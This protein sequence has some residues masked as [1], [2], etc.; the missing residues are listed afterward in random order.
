VLSF[1][2]EPLG[3]LCGRDAGLNVCCDDLHLAQGRP[4]Q[5]QGTRG[6]RPTVSQGTETQKP[7]CLGVSVANLLLCELV[8]ALRT[9]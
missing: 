2:A 9:P 1:V 8:P 4:E 7:P 5:R 3:L 6:R